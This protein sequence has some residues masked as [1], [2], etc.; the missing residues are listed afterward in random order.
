MDLTFGN[1]S[2]RLTEREK[3]VEGKK[4]SIRKAAGREAGKK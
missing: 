3:K 1:D 4:G 2:N